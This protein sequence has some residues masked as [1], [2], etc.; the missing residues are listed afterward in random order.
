MPGTRNDEVLKLARA[1]HARLPA[2]RLAPHEHEDFDKNAQLWLR[3]AADTSQSQGGGYGLGL[4][5][6]VPEATALAV[7]TAQTA[8]GSVIESGLRRAWRSLAGVRRRTRGGRHESPAGLSDAE[9]EKV[10]AR[11]IARLIGLGASE[12]IAV[13]YADSAVAE[14]PQ[15]DSETGR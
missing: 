13:L 11:I 9:R 4:Q 10:R 3:Q 2:E 1:V 6:I 12:Q 15:D 5:D 8:L 7:M 14:L